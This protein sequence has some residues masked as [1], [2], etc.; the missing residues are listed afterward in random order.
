MENAQEQHVVIGTGPLGQ[1]VIRELLAR[2]KQVRAVNRHGQADLPNAVEVV[3]GNATDAASMANVCAGATVVY[4]CVGLP[5]TD[6]VEGFPPVMDGLIAGAAS[7]EAK[8][9]FGDNLYAYGRVNDSIHEGLPNQAH[10]RKGRVRA[11]IAETLL[12]AHRDGKVRTVIGR[13]SDFYGPGVTNSAVG[14]RVMT[15][16]LAG[17]AADFIGDLDQPHTYTYIDDFG[18]ALV[19][20]GESEAALGQIWHVPNAKT[21][22]SRAFIKQVYAQAGN[23]PKVNVLPNWLLSLLALFS[24]MMRELKEM[25]YEFDEPFIVDDSKYTAAFGDHP[26]TPVE[27]GIR[28]TLEWYRARDH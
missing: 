25:T 10:T 18:K 8:L 28:H 3:A 19:N 7:A 9:V 1:A 20:L 4:G 27:E 24:P 21:I 6:W 5:Y 16:A 12:Q 13:G 17:K 23:P 11:Q 2:G 14:E 15:N 26:A 22:T